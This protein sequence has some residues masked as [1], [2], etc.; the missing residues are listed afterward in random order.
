ML[1][2]R[3]SEVI[4]RILAA[5]VGVVDERALGFPGRRRH[6]RGRQAVIRQP[7]RLTEINA[8][9]DAAQSARLSA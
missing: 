1:G 9:V 2:E 5:T 7:T 8:I 4:A 6:D 3:F